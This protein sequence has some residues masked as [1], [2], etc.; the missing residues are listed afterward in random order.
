MADP[1]TIGLAAFSAIK[2]GVAAGKEIQ[3]LAGDIGSLWDS[4][5]AIKA[6]HT[7]KKSR[8]I[9][10]VNEEAMETFIAKKQAEDMEN[11]IREL[12]V[13]TRGLD[14]WHELIRLRVQIKKDRVAAEKKAKAERKE[15]LDTILISLLILAGVSIIGLFFWFII[16]TKQESPA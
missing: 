9:L 6:D 11:Q 2:A 8:K 12:I 4:I 1:I 13:N 14:A 7:K 3:S 15:T 5:E 10:S 16:K